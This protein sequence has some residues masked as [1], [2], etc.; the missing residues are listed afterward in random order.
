MALVRD[1]ACPALVGALLPEAQ[2]RDAAV[3]SDA[4][5]FVVKAGNALTVSARMF[6]LD[7]G[8][9]AAS[10]A[11]ACA[12]AGIGEIMACDRP[13]HVEADWRAGTVAAMAA[14]DC[15]LKVGGQSFAVKGEGVNKPSRE[16]K[17]QTFKL[18][19]AAAAELRRIAE[20]GMT[21]M[22]AVAALKPASESG[23]AV[24]NRAEIM[25]RVYAQRRCS[26]QGTTLLR[27]GALR[28]PRRSE[29]RRQ[30]GGLHRL[31][32]RRVGRGGRR[33]QVALVLQRQG[34][35]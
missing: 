14:E 31:S 30:A 10:D 32:R 15:T 11:T 9:F 6:L 35:H 24:A 20:S 8:S 13:V 23:P 2:G 18:N 26:G 12:F 34:R 22:A 4:D 19:K 29:R 33:G 21:A 5:R 17:P 27:Q 7:A 16:L 3:V 25:M 1:P 28:G